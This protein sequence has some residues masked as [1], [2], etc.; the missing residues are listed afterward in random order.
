MTLIVTLRTERVT[1]AGIAIALQNVAEEFA[2]GTS[3]SISGVVRYGT[4]TERFS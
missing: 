4:F 3:F 2:F 1:S